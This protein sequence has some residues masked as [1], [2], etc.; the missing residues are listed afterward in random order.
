M[1][2]AFF[3]IRFLKSNIDTLVGGSTNLIKYPLKHKTMTFA[4][5]R[6]AQNLL[7]VVGGIA[8][9][10]T[11]SEMMHPGSVEK[12]PR[13]SDFGKIKIGD[14]RFDV[15]GGMGTLVVLASRIALTQH[16]G[17][18]GL[19]RKSSTSGKW[20]NLT[21]GKYGEDNGLDVLITTLFENKLSPLAGVA[22][23]GLKGEHFGGEEIT[24][25]SIAKN[26][27]VP[28][29]ITNAEELLKNKN[30]APL[31]RSIILEGVGIGVNTYE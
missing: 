29:S 16:N 25:A 6:S 11:I 17:E 2:A 1:N 22:R 10:L 15:T 31:I 12:D 8:S 26:L 27:T 18:W 30:S 19:W 24:P 23:D 5:K 13:S 3:S 28:L 4:Q 20:T 21:A 7:K 14:T 9:I